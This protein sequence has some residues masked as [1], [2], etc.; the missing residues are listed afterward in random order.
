[1]FVPG[2]GYERNP[3]TGADFAGPRAILEQQGYRTLLIEPDELGTVEE[4][5][6]I[7]AERLREL[8]EN[9]SRIV[10]V[11]TS[12][13]GPEVALALGELLPV[14]ESAHVQAWI[15]VGGLL[16]GSPQ[17]D[18]ALRWPK[19]WFAKTVLW[20]KVLRP[21][22]IENLSTGVRRPAF[23]RLELPSHVLMVQYVGVPLSGQV[24]RKV[25]GRYRKMRRLGPNDGLTLLADE[26]VPGGIVV[27]DVGLDHYYRDPVIDQKTIALVTIV[28]E[29]LDP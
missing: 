20:F 6:T 15:S 23:D 25:H 8:A 27:T 12:K 7:I 22:I 2:Y 10:L 19:R 18:R 5:A 11:S 13:G 14:G 21:G 24:G 16:R 9:E 3:E 29:E 28:L 26:L 4:N 1:M 17:A